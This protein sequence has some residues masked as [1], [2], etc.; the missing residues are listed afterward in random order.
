MSVPVPQGSFEQDERT[1]S[2]LTATPPAAPLLW[3]CHSQRPRSS[4][5]L[6]PRGL[7]R[8]PAQDRVAA[9][10]RHQAVRDT[11]ACC[12]SLQPPRVQP[13][14]ARFSPHPHA[15]PLPPGLPPPDSRQR[16]AVPGRPR[17]P[18]GG[19]DG[20]GPAGPAGARP[21][22]AADAGPAPRP[23][24]RGDAA[25]SSAPLPACEAPGQ[26]R[27]WR[28]PGS[29]PLR[30]SGGA[31]ATATGPAAPAARPCLSRGRAE[32]SPSDPNRAEPSRAQPSAAAPTLC[33][34]S[35]RVL[36]GASWENPHAKTRGVSA[37]SSREDSCSSVPGKP[38]LP[39]QGGK[40][41]WSNIHLSAT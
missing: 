23:A 32:P 28:P 2:E 20:P 10:D 18:G 22:P 33:S 25:A 4:T 17:S 37:L 30:R 41:S 6:S 8:K 24:E 12:G 34:S 19:R 29:P 13:G 21:G 11:P 26:P 39:L 35:P 16:E 9:R 38:V 40:Q 27:R 5:G 7:P 31:P 3:K 14:G 36:A 15:S 1:D